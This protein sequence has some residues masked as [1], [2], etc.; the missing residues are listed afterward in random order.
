M[1]RPM[2]FFKV[3]NEADMIV[4]VIQTKDIISH[5]A[6][7]MA[8]FGI[9]RYVYFLIKAMSPKMFFFTNLLF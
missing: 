3:G 8:S 4:G 6:T 1:A 9:V 2:Q 7:I 5:P